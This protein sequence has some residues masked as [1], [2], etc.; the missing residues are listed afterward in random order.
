MLGETMTGSPQVIKGP[1]E[2][3]LEEIERVL[4]G[5][6]ERMSS[7]GVQ[8]ISLQ[9]R[10]VGMTREGVLGNEWLRVELENE[11]Q[12]WEGMD[13]RLERMSALEREVCRCENEIVRFPFLL[14]LS[15]LFARL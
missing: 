13:L 4:G 9:N 8:I 2:S 5:M 1:L 6:R 10:L 12:G 7:R 15:L 3:Q 14:L 11:S